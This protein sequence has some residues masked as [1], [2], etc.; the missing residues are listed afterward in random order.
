VT[1]LRTAAERTQAL[2]SMYRVRAVEEPPDARGT[3]HIWH[4]GATGADLLTLV[5]AEG[6]VLRQELQL[7]DDVLVWERG[8]PLKTGVAREVA[9]AGRMKAPDDVVYDR[10]EASKARVAT[11][12]EALQGYRGDDRCLTHLCTRLVEALTLQ[13]P[14]L[15][16]QVTRPA[17][18]VSA[19][20][21]LVLESARKAAALRRM[22]PW[23][24]WAAV[25]AVS[26][27]VT[28]LLLMK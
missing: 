4:R 13:G 14:A 8:Q 10:A 23:L 20:A 25:L 9:G 27:L 21:K 28:T 1:L 18:Q 17:V 3:R 16:V 26:A 2:E 24:L 5:D 15:E 12:S 11:L 19:E 6:L 7:F 22:R